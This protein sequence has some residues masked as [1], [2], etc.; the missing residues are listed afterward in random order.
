MLTAIQSHVAKLLA[1]NR[2]QGNYFA[3]GAVLNQ[4]TWRLSD[5]L[6]IFTNA[7]EEI[8]DIVKADLAS[9]DA[10][11]FDVR[12]DLEVYGCAEATVRNGPDETLIQWMSETKDRFYPLQDD[13][14]WGLRLHMTDLAVNKVLA[15]STRR[16]SRDLVDLVLIAENYCE[17]GPL[18]MA[19]SIK[20]GNMSPLA[21]LE[22]ARQHLVSTPV[23]DLDTTRGI[24]D[25][26]RGADLKTLAMAALDCAEVFLGDAPVEWMAGL[27]VDAE[28]RPVTD[29]ADVFDLR[30]LSAE[31]GRFPEFPDVSPDFGG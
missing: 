19:A 11:G 3:G 28:G 6:D 15:A 26:M 1:A 25:G 9:L 27:P 8:P 5:D 30:R 20:I 14:D 24:P 17:L 18:F 29:P 23:D 12:I 7:D 31:G 4:R 22:R 16:K 13:P 21:L 10:A 2:R